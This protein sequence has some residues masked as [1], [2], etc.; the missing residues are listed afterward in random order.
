MFNAYIGGTFLYNSELWTLTQTQS[1][2]IDSIQRKFLRKIL[3]LTWPKIISNEKLYEKTEQK[4]WSETVK[5]RMFRWLGHLMRMDKA[6]PARRALDEFI[7]KG[8]RPVGRPKETWLSVVRR[9]LGTSEL[10]I[11]LRSDVTMIEELERIC[12]DRV[13]WRCFVRNMKL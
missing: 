5:K 9:I 7:K 8:R 13:Q 3:Q 4:P 11:D 6:T 2:T 10:K 12:E 1:N